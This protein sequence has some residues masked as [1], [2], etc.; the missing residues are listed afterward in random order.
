MP[1]SCRDLGFALTAS[2]LTGCLL[3]SDFEG[4]TTPQDSTVPAPDAPVMPAADARLPQG[5]TSPPVLADARADADATAD[6]AAAFRPTPCIGRRECLGFDEAL[7]SSVSGWYVDQQGGGTTSYD[8]TTFATGPGALR[9]RFTVL[10]R[11]GVPDHALLYKNVVASEPATQLFWGFDARL[12]ACPGNAATGAAVTLSSLQLGSGS[13]YGLVSSSE[14]DLLV[15][16]RGAE[17]GPSNFALPLLPRNEWLHLDFAIAMSASDTTFR[18]ALNGIELR[19]VAINVDT[20]SASTLLNVG[21]LT[22][23]PVEECVTHFD[24]YYFDPSAPP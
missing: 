1:R 21:I 19:T 16:D 23:D 7:P 6:A 22:Q 15:V 20:P 5:D 17:A 2:V 8:S 9:A 11:P 14:G 10:P 24:N 4:I 3:T 13:V 12:G 18:V